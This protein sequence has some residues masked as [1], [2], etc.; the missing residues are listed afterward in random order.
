MLLGLP[1]TKLSVG[2]NFDCAFLQFFSMEIKVGFQVVI[3]STFSSPDTSLSTTITI[4]NFHL[5]KVFLNDWL[6]LEFH[7]WRNAELLDGRSTECCRPSRNRSPERNDLDR[8]S[9]VSTSRDTEIVFKIV[10]CK[11]NITS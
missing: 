6:T 11:L 9:P 7:W 3:E 8:L 10:D 2:R 1:K 4:D 5:M